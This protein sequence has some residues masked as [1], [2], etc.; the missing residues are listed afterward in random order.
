MRPTHDTA[1][2]PDAV[3]R[4]ARAELRR[5]LVAGE[6]CG[7]EQFLAAYPVLASHP[8]RAIALICAEWHARRDLGQSPSVQEWCRRF[9]QYREQLTDRLGGDA[10]SSHQD[11]QTVLD[12][13]DG[14]PRPEPPASNLDA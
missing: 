2:D 4:R 5:R 7:A 14:T 12:P 8:E 1:D 11:A 10:D 3:L 6:P 9:P 13:P